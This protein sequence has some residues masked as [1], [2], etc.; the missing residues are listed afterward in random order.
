MEKFEI[1]IINSNIQKEK[2]RFGVI[3]YRVNGVSLMFIDLF[4]KM[5]MFTEK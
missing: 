4:Q 3:I 1:N 2:C 5:E